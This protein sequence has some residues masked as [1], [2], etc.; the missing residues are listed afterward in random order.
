M[1]LQATKP[2]KAA[3]SFQWLSLEAV[4]VLPFGRAEHWSP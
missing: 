3:D 4:E 1:P 2:M